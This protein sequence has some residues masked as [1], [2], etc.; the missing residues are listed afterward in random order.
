LSSKGR[1][2]RSLRRL[3]SCYS[4]KEFYLPGSPSIP[5]CFPEHGNVLPS[6]AA[7]NDFPRPILIRSHVIVCENDDIPHKVMS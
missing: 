5:E 6:P 1:A 4:G 7:G 3:S 2:N